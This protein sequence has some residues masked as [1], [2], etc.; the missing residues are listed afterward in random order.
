MRGFPKF[1]FSFQ[2]LLRRGSEYLALE[3]P[4]VTVLGHHVVHLTSTIHL[5]GPRCIQ[6]LCISFLSYLYRNI[7]DSPQTGMENIYPW[8]E[9]L[10]RSEVQLY[11]YVLSHSVVQLYLTLCNC[12]DYRPPDSSVHGI[13]QARILEWVASS[14][15][16]GSS[17]PR[18]RTRVSCVSCIGWWIL[19]HWATWEAL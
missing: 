15:S 8:K 14:S 6:M 2:E 1:Y 7:C 17:Q 13:L 18:D 12:M 19:C 9:Q 11:A 4:H 5:I 3:W 10:P 16:R